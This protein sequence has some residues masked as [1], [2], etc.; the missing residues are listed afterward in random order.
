MKKNS[1]TECLVC[2]NAC[3]TLF[4]ECKDHF[5]SGEKYEVARCED[6]GFKYTV[7]PPDEK[8]ILK[9]YQSKSYISH[10]NTNK[11]LINNLYHKIRSIMLR[12]KW[13]LLRSVS[14]G[15]MLLDY[16]CGTGYFLNYMQHKGYNVY[17]METEP[18]A[19]MFALENFKIKVSPPDELLNEKHT[20]QFD[21]IT[22]WHVMEHLHYPTKSLQWIYDSLKEDGTLII[23][24]PNCSSYDARYYRQFW[25]AYDVPR[26][27]WHFDPFTLGNY[28]SQHGFKQVFLKRMPF[29]AYYNSMLSARYA[30]NTISFAHGLFIGFISNLISL[31]NHKKS[32]SVIYVFRKNKQ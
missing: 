25:A 20:G 30:Q 11:G 12:R 4:I 10:S 28:M 6:C 21:I 2:G 7:N 27:L 23:A 26:H 9:Y 29:D 19:R 31:F 13:K 5:V 1:V 8:E 15:K 14:N 24:L 3:K 22:L 32:S 18:E 17:G 16:G